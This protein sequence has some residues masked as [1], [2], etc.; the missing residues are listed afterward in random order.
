MSTTTT[1][2]PA[3]PATLAEKM[4]AR[5]AQARAEVEALI[6]AGES[7][8]KIIDAAYK[9]GLPPEEIEAIEKKAREAMAQAE[10]LAA[11]DLAVLAAA[12]KAANKTASQAADVLE[13]AQEA[14]AEAAFA[15]R[16][17]AFAFAD[18][19]KAFMDV[20]SAV[21]RGEIPE[22]HVPERCKRYLEK[23]ALQSKAQ[24]ATVQRDQIRRE[25]NAI[26]A[27]ITRLQQRQEKIDGHYTD[28]GGQC[29]VVNSGSLQSEGATLAAR[30]DTLQD[31]VKQA[32]KKMKALEKESADAASKAEKLAVGLWD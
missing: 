27:E 14:H 12:E 1:K 19:Q 2:A 32:E 3:A 20:A 8:D 11:L 18:A 16:E 7:N 5:T 9:G 28:H 10:A 30:I 6:W 15:A 25:K 4:K 24:Q 26:E 31:L 29:V 13:R 23:C 17:A 22:K 21:A